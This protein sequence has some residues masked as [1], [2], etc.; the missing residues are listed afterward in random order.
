M[1]TP[2]G[3]NSPIRR[4]WPAWR[5]DAPALGDSVRPVAAAP[6]HAGEEPDRQAMV[7]ETFAA[8]QT[9]VLGLPA[10]QQQAFLL[11][12]AEGMDVAETALAMECSQGSVKTHYSRAVHSLRETLG[13]Y[14]R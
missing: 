6:A 10:R 3:D 11:R 14:W 5:L 12:I 7:G 4:R 8:L 13:D 2:G 9:A 1:G